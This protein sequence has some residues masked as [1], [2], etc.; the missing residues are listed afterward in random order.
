MIALGVPEPFFVHA[1]HP[2]HPVN[3][4]FSWIRKG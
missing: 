1:I 2:L 4:C 3:M